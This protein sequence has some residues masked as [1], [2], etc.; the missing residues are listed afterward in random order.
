[1]MSWLEMQFLSFV[2]TSMKLE[3]LE[4]EKTY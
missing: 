2:S 1:M 4:R 3:K